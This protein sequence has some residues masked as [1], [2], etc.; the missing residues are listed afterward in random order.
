VAARPSGGAGEPGGGR[1][2]GVIRIQRKRTPGWR[3]PP[4]SVYV[5]RPSRVN[6]LASTQVMGRLS[7]KGR[8]VLEH[9]EPG[10]AVATERAP[11]VVRGMVMVP[12][13]SS[14]APADCTLGVEAAARAVGP[15]IELDSLIGLRGA[16]EPR[17]AGTRGDLGRPANSACGRLGLWIDARQPVSES[18]GLCPRRDVATPQMAVVASDAEAACPGWFPAP[19]F[20]AGATIKLTWDGCHD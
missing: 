14:G 8:V 1:G 11:V 17:A 10:V 20:G 5:G 16:S 3:M 19:R 13:Q 4:G 15:L 6:G 18:L 7:E 2:D 12:N 9:T